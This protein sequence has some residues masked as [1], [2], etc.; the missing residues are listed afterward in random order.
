MESTPQ[1]SVFGVISQGML[2]TGTLCSKGSRLVFKKHKPSGR[3][4]VASDFKYARHHH[5]VDD[6]DKVNGMPV[7]YC[8]NRPCDAKRKMMHIFLP[9]SIKE[10]GRWGHT[11]TGWASRVHSLWRSIQTKLCRASQQ[12]LP[13]KRHT[14]RGKVVPTGQPVLGSP[15]PAVVKTSDFLRALFDF[16]FC[17]LWD[18]KP[19]HSLTG[20]VCNCRGS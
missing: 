8:N 12:V 13:P 16:C 19:S 10:Q 11:T 9:S 14:R 3:K 7:T 17:F 2:S 15:L 18:S 20:L 6:I 4:L 1:G 5:V